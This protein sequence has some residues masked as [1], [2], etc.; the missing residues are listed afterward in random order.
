MD[1]FVDIFAEKLRNQETDDNFTFPGTLKIRFFSSK[2][3]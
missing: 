1:I 2:G 3:G